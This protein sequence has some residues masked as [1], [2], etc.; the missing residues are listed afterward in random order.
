MWMKVNYVSGE[1]VVRGIDFDKRYISAPLLNYIKKH[2]IHNNFKGVLNIEIK[3]QVCEKC[4][5]SRLVLNVRGY[6]E[7]NE[8]NY[9]SLILYGTGNSV[10]DVISND[11]I[12]IHGWRSNKSNSVVF[13]YVTITNETKEMFTKDFEEKYVFENNINMPVIPFH[14]GIKRTKYIENNAEMNKLLY[15]TWTKMYKDC[16]NCFSKT[17]EE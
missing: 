6:K 8:N 15:N 16:P 10:P 2:M 11:S 14:K 5:S 1:K 4:N 13:G 9:P 7:D 12:E 17:L 3:E